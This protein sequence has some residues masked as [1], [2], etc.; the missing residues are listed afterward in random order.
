MNGLA[1]RDNRSFSETLRSV[2]VFSQR[3]LEQWSLFH[4][5]INYV[6]LRMPNALN[7]GAMTSYE[8][9]Y[10]RKPAVY[11]FRILGS[12]AYVLTADHVSLS[13]TRVSYTGYLVAYTPD[14]SPGYVIYNPNTNRCCVSWTVNTIFDEMFLFHQAQRLDGN[15]DDYRGLFMYTPNEDIPDFGTEAPPTHTFPRWV[16]TGFYRRY[17]HN[18]PLD[19]HRV[20]T[21]AVDDDIFDNDHQSL[22]HKDEKP[23]DDP[24]VHV[25]SAPQIP[26][27]IN[28][29]V[30]QAVDPIH[31][32]PPVPA[33]VV[34]IEP[35][36]I[37]TNVATTY[38]ALSGPLMD[39]SRN[40][41]RTQH[42]FHAS[43]PLSSVV[44]GRVI[45]SPSQ[46]SVMNALATHNQRE[47]ER[48]V[49]DV[50]LNAVCSHVSV[51]SFHS[52]M[53]SPQEAK[54][55]MLSTVC[56]L[57]EATL[58]DIDDPGHD[59]DPVPHNDVYGDGHSSICY[60]G[61]PVHERAHSEVPF[62]PSQI[63]QAEILECLSSPE[64][65]AWKEVMLE[66]ILSLDRIG[67]WE[68]WL[69]P[70]D[71]DVNIVET[72][73]LCVRKFNDD[74]GE[75]ER[76][77]AR[78]VCKGFTQQ[79]GVDFHDVY[80]PVINYTCVRCTLCFVAHH[81][82]ELK[83]LDIKSAFVQ[84]KLDETIFV[85][86]IP[87]F[88]PKPRSD[89]ILV[90][91]LRR[92]WYGLK[93]ASRSWWMKLDGI[94]K[95]FGFVP[96]TADKCLYILRDPTTKA[97]RMLICT[98]VD[99]MLAAYAAKDAHL[100]AQLI[101]LLQANVNKPS[102]VKDL[103]DATGFA[104]TAIIRN[105]AQKTI[106]WSQPKIVDKLKKAAAL[107][108]FV[109]E[110][111]GKTR[112]PYP[113]PSNTHLSKAACPNPG[114]QEWHHMQKKP[115]KELVGLLLFLAI[116]SRPEILF[117]VVDSCRFNANPGQAHW[118][119]LRDVIR[120][121]LSFPDIGLTID[122]RIDLAASFHA[123][124][125]ADFA[126]DRD[127][128]RSVSGYV[129]MLANIAIHWVSRFQHLVAH[130]S[131]ESELIAL[132]ACA[133]DALWLIRLLRDDLQLT[134]G[135]LTIW[136]DNSTVLHRVREN[137]QTKLTRHIGTR[138]YSV[139]D[140]LHAKVIDPRKIDSK[141]N[142]ANVLTKVTTGTDFTYPRSKL[143]NLP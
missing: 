118:K 101:A 76:Y 121:V 129:F 78:V 63:K 75:F 14:P 70:N 143:L 140:L 127:T 142:V 44:S 61:L 43:S 95:S 134:I 12:P 46:S 42:M 74:T 49:T 53:T 112:F 33:T 73:W 10:K 36:S 94:L 32:G 3:P 83:R 27:V 34:E 102:D 11:Y 37:D 62:D 122:G 92:S 58:I 110:R 99:D 17:D 117:N 13:K 125:D 2:L 18:N 97:I 9:L 104:G 103:G 7:P 54:C 24:P 67:T 38:V 41:T 31:I 130:S 124:C 5:G 65:Q 133:T 1:E 69:L 52:D 16:P 60:V 50:Y 26:G 51:D 141:E 68:W 89:G 81:D 48:H 77:K 116:M 126:T 107:H 6:Q 131:F 136:C 64:G 90:L 98:L 135:P 114:S 123:Y 120:H 86:P 88:A 19:T 45:P 91:K 111:N 113:V 93:Q 55:L 128:R 59:D 80:S 56:W 57:N 82:W 108:G 28:Q 96:A 138:F 23:E 4:D 66:E 106:H 29:D 21:N 139:A 39:E 30:A 35:H 115:Y 132:F 109:P 72:K 22:L 119:Y 40:Y 79:H 15:K 100:Y 47:Y 25:K 85:R 87:G 137:V 20:D 84:S 105:R 8:M 71:T